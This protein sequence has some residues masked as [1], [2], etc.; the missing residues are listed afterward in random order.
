MA[1][2]AEQGWH[3]ANRFGIG[4]AEAAAATDLFRTEGVRRANLIKNTNQAFYAFN[5][6]QRSMLPDALRPMMS[7][8]G[9]TL[10]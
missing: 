3:L 8:C 4:A 9:S 1:V 6:L 7:I 10:S 5:S 2:T